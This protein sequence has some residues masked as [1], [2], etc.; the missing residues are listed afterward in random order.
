MTGGESHVRI[1]LL[2]PHVVQ[3]HVVG[4]GT[5]AMV[6]TVDKSVYRALAALPAGAQQVHLFW[7]L[8]QLETYE[9]AFRQTAVAFHNL[10]HRR[11]HVL[12]VHAYMRS[13]IVK[14]GAQVGLLALGALGQK[15]KLYHQEL[16]YKGALREALLWKGTVR[17]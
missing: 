7:E 6:E 9:S 16:A 12:T 3:V 1:E 8:S 17:P 11:G 2:S 13:Q 10:L 5:A 4:Y 15:I 14:M